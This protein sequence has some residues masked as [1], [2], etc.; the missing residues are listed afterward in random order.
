MN[1]LGHAFLSFGN[2]AILTG[3]MLGDHVKGKL[4]LDNYPEQIKKGLILHRKIDGFA[5]IHSAHLQAKLL[6]KGVYGL[7]SS[8]IVDT[9][10]DHYI[11]C[12]HKLFPT[13]S[14][15]YLFS[16]TVYSILEKNEDVFPQQFASMFNHMRQNN[17][18]YNY[19]NFAGIR[20][21]LNGLARRAK[22]LP[23]ID[24]AYEIFI[25]N[26]YQI[27]QYYFDFM[28]DMIKFSRNEIVK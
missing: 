25:T 20:Q 7:Y 19:R 16:Q 27:N 23:P 10:F 11:A 21:S 26:Y 18:L 8:P 22:Y 14:S 24:K 4:A 9:L 1:Y 6:F 13:E 15:L 5:D 3:N 28:A 17:W 2:D 12:D